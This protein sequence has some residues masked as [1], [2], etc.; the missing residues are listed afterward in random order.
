LTLALVLI[1]GFVMYQLDFHSGTLTRSMGSV[2]A[3]E[4]SKPT[5]SAA[6]LQSATPSPSLGENNTK[7]PPQKVPSQNSEQTPDTMSGLAWKSGVSFPNV[8]AYSTAAAEETNAFGTWRDRPVDVAVAW[9]NRSSW[10]SFTN[11]NPLYTTWAKQPY[12]KVFALP[13]FPENIGD[14]VNGCIAG[15]YE[16][17]WRTFAKTMASTGLAA[18]GSIIRLGWEMNLHT[19]WGNPA[20]FAAC[21][22]NIVSTVKAIAPGLLWDWNVNRG[23]STGMPGAN[24][25]SAYP[26]NNYV[27]IIGVDSYDDWPPATTGTGWQQQ[28]DGPYGLD[29]W[30]AFAKEHGE[31]FSVPEWGV[32]SNVAWGDEASGDDPGYIEDMYNF[33]VANSAALAFEAYFNSDGTAIYDPVQNPNSSAEY[34]RLWSAATTSA[35]ASMQRSSRPISQLSLTGKFP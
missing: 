34:Q 5:H 14:T 7:K 33:F 10:T 12:K 27:N 8:D 26:G 15:N 11:S 16:G 20:Q 19:D 24:V 21:W 23:S 2:P 31:K 17:H 32:D 13:L 28:L 3:P 6:T 25:L 4:P 1:G 29:Y 35:S 30:L 22:R 9:T 18:Q